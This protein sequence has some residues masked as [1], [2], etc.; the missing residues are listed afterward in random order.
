M[1][2]D[3]GGPLP[4]PP[5]L[6]PGPPPGASGDPGPAGGRGIRFGWAALLLTLAAV[7][8]AGPLALAI[9]QRFLRPTEEEIRG[10]I[11]AALQ[12]ERPETF[13][14][15]GSLDLTATTT[16]RNTRRLLPGIVDLSLG[17]TSATVRMP[18]RVSYGLDLSRIHPRDVR[19]DDSGAVTVVVPP[20]T[21]WSTEPVLTE[22]EVQTEVGWARLY[23]RSGRAVEQEAIRLM[24]TALRRQGEAHLAD[25]DQP[26]R[27]SAEALERL[28]EPALAAAG[29]AD[30]RVT[31]LF[32]DSPHDREGD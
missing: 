27:N 7:L 22:M 10:A 23:A 19:V 25:S 20:P 2:D 6:R 31:V 3:H 28:L 8:V 13:L 16:V 5:D 15:T 21:V 11:Y 24:E 1:T 4:P 17:T 9:T 29:V 12:R 14:V 26:R 30:P 18:G 32:S